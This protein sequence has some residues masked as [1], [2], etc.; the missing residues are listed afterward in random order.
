MYFHCNDGGKDLL[1]F[2]H[3]LWCLWLIKFEFA[4]A[5]S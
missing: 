1:L 2:I 4:T 5:G 3:D